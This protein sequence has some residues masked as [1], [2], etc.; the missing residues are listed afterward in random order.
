MQ[1]REMKTYES[2]L[3]HC[4]AIPTFGDKGYSTRGMMRRCS[5][6]YRMHIHP[7]MTWL[8]FDKRVLAAKEWLKMAITYRNE[9]KTNN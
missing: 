2:L 1:R 6:L 8:S 9:S 7:E 3:A 4:G 5:L